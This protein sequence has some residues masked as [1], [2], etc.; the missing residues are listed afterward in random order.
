MQQSCQK[1]QM[2][3]GGEKNKAGKFLTNQELVGFESARW[4][5][6]NS[7]YFPLMGAKNEMILAK[8]AASSSVG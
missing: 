3:F 7:G 6:P 1:F 4:P 8:S 5:M 2:Q